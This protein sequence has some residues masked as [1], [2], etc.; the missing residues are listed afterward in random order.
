MHRFDFERWLDAWGQ[1]WERLDPDAFVPLLSPDVTWLR[2]PF[3]D[4]LT[5]HE[6]VRAAIGAGLQGLGAIAYAWEFL[7]FSDGRGVAHW[8]VTLSP[9]GAPPARFDGVLVADFDG[10]GR[11]RSLREWWN[12]DER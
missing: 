5:G 7:V 9:T 1:A 6:A 3:A 12:R 10:G 11:C 4:P 8:E 2:E